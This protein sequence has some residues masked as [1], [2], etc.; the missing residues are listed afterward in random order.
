MKKSRIQTLAS[1]A[2]AVVAAAF[3]FTAHMPD[4]AR[5]ASADNTVTTLMSAVTDAG[6]T[7]ASGVSTQV[8]PA[9]GGS[10][11]YVFQFHS[12]VS[13]APLVQVQMSPD[14]TLWATVY[15]FGQNGPD[16]VWSTPTCGGCQFQLNKLATT[17]AKATVKLTMSGP[18]VALAPT[19]TA[20]STPTATPTP[21]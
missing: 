13:P 19:Y 21:H 18:S 6:V 2:L 16:E 14:G 17:T 1:L 20:S 15:T 7:G 12:D 9:A 4:G 8:T 10:D 11:R 3:L 5:T